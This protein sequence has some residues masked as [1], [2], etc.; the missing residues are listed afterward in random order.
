MSGKS[1]LRIAIDGPAASGKSTTARMVAEK[2][3]FLYIDTGA[4]YRALT[5]AVLRAKIDPADE[6]AIAKLAHETGIELIQSS[7]GVKTIL[8]GEDVSAD[9][10]LPEVTRVISIVS[11][12]AGLRRIMVEKQR[13]LALKENVVMEG[14]DIGTKVLPDA[15]IKVFMVASIEQRAE[16]RF[17][18][19]SAKGVKVDLAEI[20]REIKM[21]DDLD[22]TREASPLKPAHDAVHLDTSTLSIEQQVEKV[23]E[24]V[25]EFQTDTDYQSE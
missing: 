8:N 18:E 13:Q 11:A 24:L 3:G 5:V 16:R 20:A 6:K 10:R 1:L 21:R 2:L 22:S 12:H 9:I 25:R 7:G 23:L 14:R 17:T 19:L 4:M 15:E